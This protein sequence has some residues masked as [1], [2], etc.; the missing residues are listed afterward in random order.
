MPTNDENARFHVLFES[1]TG[2]IG[3]REEGHGIVG[4]SDFRVN[5]AV[6]EWVWAFR[7][8]EQL[9]DGTALLIVVTGSTSRLPAWVTEASTRILTSTFRKAA[10]LIV[11]I[12][13]MLECPR[14]R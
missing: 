2:Q 4:N 3:A 7:P 14:R 11:A 6:G 9:A 1:M 5:P 12:T 13:A 10:S 8:S